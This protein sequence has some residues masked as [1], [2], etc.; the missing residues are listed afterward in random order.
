[1]KLPFEGGL[2][3]LFRQI[4]DKAKGGGWSDPDTGQRHFTPWAWR[5][6]NGVYV[7]WDGS[8][9]L[10]RALPLE[11]W[12]WADDPVRMHSGS[13]LSTAFRDIAALSR[14][15]PVANQ[16]VSNAREFHLV[17]ITWE[18]VAQPP[19]DNPQPLREY[20]AAAFADMLVPRR[21]VLF[22][23]RLRPTGGKNFSTS[24][25]DQLMGAL[26]QILGDDVP[27]L[28]KYQSDY[29]DVSRILARIDA[30]V[31]TREET[32]QLE[33]WYN[34][35]RS[36]EAIIVEEGDRLIID[37]S[38]AI[39]MTA[40]ADFDD[41]VLYAPRD[42]WL[43]DLLSH[44]DAPHLVSIR[45]EMQHPSVA[46]NRFRQAQRWAYDQAE[47][48]SRTGDIGRRESI[49]AINLTQVLDDHYAETD[50]PLL[51]K[52]SIVL[53]RRVRDF[54]ETYADMLKNRYA[55]D[56]L[57]LLW[58]QL[59]ALDET[60]PTSRKRVNPWPQEI[61]TEVITYSGINAWSELGDQTGLLAGVTLEDRVPVY[62][63][64]QGAPKKN[65]PATMAVLGDSGSGKTFLL[66]HLAVQGA[67]AGLPV[68]MINPKGMDS[69]SPTAELVGGD[70]IKLTQIQ[71]EG[72][73]FDPFRYAEPQMAA[74]IAARHI[75]SVL[76]FNQVDEIELFRG[77]A[78]GAA[79]GARCVADALKYVRAGIAKQVTDLAASNAQFSIA[80]GK[81]P[82]PPLR[83]QSRF[84]LIEFD[85]ELGLPPAYKRASEH[86][87]NEKIALATMRIITRAA[88]EIVAGGQGGMVIVD[89]AWTFLNQEEG[90]EVLERI[91]REGRSLNVLPILATQY[92][93]DIR[94][95]HMDGLL[96]RVICLKL[97]DPDEAQAGLE[98]IGVEPTPARIQ[99]LAQAGPKKQA[100]GTVLPSI[101]LFRDLDNRRG[102]IAVYP[103][104][105]KAALAFA[106]DPEGRA[107]QRRVKDAETTGQLQAAGGGDSFDSGY[108][109]AGGADDIT[110]HAGIAGDATVGNPT[111]SQ[112]SERLDDLLGVNP[113][114]QS[115]GQ[116][117]PSRHAEA[118][119]LPEAQPSRP[120]P[121]TRAA[122]AR[123]EAAE[124]NNPDEHTP[125]VSVSD[126]GWE[127]PPTSKPKLRSG[128][129][130]KPKPAPRSNDESEPKPPSDGWE[131]L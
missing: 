81:V 66:Q 77:L 30:R 38:D 103:V 3:G 53:G 115:A 125:W 111:A 48:E 28:D 87:T 8:V 126:T 68:I 17:A 50:L 62:I 93:K 54:T 4:S 101:G 104:P 99:G 94:D 79:A 95:R 51:T 82:Q 56:A 102:A 106:T 20:Q 78:E 10:Y 84:T 43:M 120:D 18:T 2:K 11:P 34:K 121:E 97:S 16:L 80:I 9:W 69:L 128:V 130:R 73:W 13:T 12:V 116:P 42:T 86:T 96:S 114:A 37:D 117:E 92:V 110:D 26:F 19:H 60:L 76:T 14:P 107:A 32:R 47:E 122:D 91:G 98:L 1:M 21:V 67:L 131:R 72:G 89:E 112:M 36:A 119:N 45:G 127:R 24:T 27:D 49:D 85:R 29:Q 23:V 6:R 15:A 5:T 31:P 46:R 71:K 100:N 88:L 113:A 59:D 63:D 129:R 124:H 41:P 22:G 25:T 52:T 123:G 70:V 64:P 33:A 55:I 61:S 118:T 90:Q 109:A 40:I 65:L 108:L 105:P 83:L 58:R 39:Q 74:E 35:G 44:Q 75:T 57:P 7:G